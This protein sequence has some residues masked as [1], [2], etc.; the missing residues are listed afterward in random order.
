MTWGKSTLETVAQN[1]LAKEK[2]TI[3]IKLK[4]SLSTDTPPGNPSI[5]K[6]QKDPKVAVETKPI[7]NQ[8][9]II[10]STIYY[11]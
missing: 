8:F 9:Y 7:H 1:T 3:Y 4:T 2:Q 6:R 11:I 5:G 10:T